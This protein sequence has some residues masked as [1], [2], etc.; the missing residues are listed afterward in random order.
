MYPLMDMLTLGGSEYL[1]YIGR[2]TKYILSTDHPRSADGL[3]KML[4]GSYDWDDLYTN[5][6]E[7]DKACL[8][9]LLEMFGFLMPDELTP[10]IIEFEKRHTWVFRHPNG[11]VFIPLELLKIF[12]RLPSFQ[13]DFWLFTLLYKLR[14]KEQKNLASLISRDFEAQISISLEQNDLDMALVLYIYLGH[15][16]RYDSLSFPPRGN[17][18]KLHYL[19]RLPEHFDYAPVYLPDHPVVLWDYL[20]EVFPRYHQDIDNLYNHLRETAISFYRAVGVVLDPTHPI[21]LA[22]QSGILIPLI[23]KG[24]YPDRIHALK[25]VAPKEAQK[26][27]QCN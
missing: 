4:A 22:F 18:A 6:E 2:K 7:G 11:G 19:Y 12:M 16:M 23:P 27:V 20:K 14:L 1:R 17:K 21:L 25:V 13:K 26:H 15:Q 5:M 8:H 9:T 3:W 10:E 24:V